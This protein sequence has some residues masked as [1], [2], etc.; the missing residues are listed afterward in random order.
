M[1]NDIW[2]LYWIFLLYPFNYVDWYFHRVL[3][4][5]MRI[6]KSDDQKINSELEWYKNTI[7]TLTVIHNQISK[8]PTTYFWE[9]G[10]L[11]TLIRTFKSKIGKLLA[12][13]YFQ[14]Q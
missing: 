4:L 14:E 3:G 5:S 11:E 13:Q 2:H 9:I 10:T 12:D 7:Q 1:S 8:D 6:G